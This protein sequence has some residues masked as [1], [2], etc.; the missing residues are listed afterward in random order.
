MLALPREGVVVEGCRKR[1][2][3]YFDYDHALLC[4]VC[5]G[6][7]DHEAVAHLLGR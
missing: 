3:V 5:R 4:G 1:S 6:S 7:G 2:S